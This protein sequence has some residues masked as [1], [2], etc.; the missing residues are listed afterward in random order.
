MNDGGL[1]CLGCGT[2]IWIILGLGFFFKKKFEKKEEQ[3]REKAREKAREFEKKEEQ[4]REKSRTLEREDIRNK[5]HENFKYLKDF[6]DDCFQTTPYG[7]KT[8][9]ID[10]WEKG[11][12]TFLEKECPV[13]EFDYMMVNEIFDEVN[14]YYENAEKSKEQFVVSEMVKHYA[15]LNMKYNRS[16]TYD[17]YGIMQFDD[18]KFDADLAYFAKNVLKDETLSKTLLFS[19]FVEAGAIAETGDFDLLQVKTGED[20]ERFV[21]ELCE[22]SAFECAMTPKTGDQGV[23]LIVSKGSIRIA[24]QC[25]YYSSAIGNAAVQEVIGGK[26]FYNCDYACVVS[27][28]DYTPQAKTLARASDVELLSHETLIPYLKK[29]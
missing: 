12:Q 8:F 21:R 23:D 24:I 3:E 11:L 13:Y 22:D 19:C 16:T 5:I 9:N 17:E 1:G 18:R 25:K 15:T 20:Y 7:K 6:E 14:E 29:L 2:V 26:N 4:E 27:N 28:Q 10:R